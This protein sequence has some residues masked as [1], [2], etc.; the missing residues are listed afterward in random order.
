MCSGRLLFTGPPEARGVECPGDKEQEGD[1]NFLPLAES[2]T[3]VSG[4]T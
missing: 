4:G 3:A 1:M 2:A